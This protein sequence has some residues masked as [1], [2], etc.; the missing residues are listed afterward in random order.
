MSKQSRDPGVLKRWMNWKPTVRILGDSAKSGPSEPTELGSVG[1]EGAP[2]AETFEI[3]ESGTSWWEWKA[4]ALN[5]LF[6]E[7]GSLEGRITGETVKHGEHRH[8][9]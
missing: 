3:Q 1:S 6:L 5:R 9:R 2:P 8:G 7:Q 4:A